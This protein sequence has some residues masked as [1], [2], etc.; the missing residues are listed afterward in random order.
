MAGIVLARLSLLRR[1]AELIREAN[2]HNMHPIA[3]YL[4]LSNQYDRQ[5][6]RHTY[7][8]LG[9]PIQLKPCPSRVTELKKRYP[10]A[11]GG[12]TFYTIQTSG[13]PEH[14]TRVSLQQVL[15]DTT[16]PIL[17][18]EED[19]CPGQDGIGFQPLKDAI[20]LH[21]IGHMRLDV[22]TNK[23][24][25]G[26]LLILAL[27]L[28]IFILCTSSLSGLLWVLGG[29]VALCYCLNHI[30]MCYHEKYAERY[31]MQ[32]SSELGMIYYIAYT[33][34]ES[35]RNK[36]HPP[37]LWQRLS[38]PHPNPQAVADMGK[39]MFATRFSRNYDDIEL[40]CIQTLE[41]A[42]AVMGNSNSM[43]CHS[44][45]LTAKWSQLAPGT[46]WGTFYNQCSG[47]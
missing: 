5:S 43:R 8:Y 29:E 16:D 41:A 14:W 28:V 4:G 32:H 44:R 18:G 9:N 13:Y 27:A 11:T 31:A 38:D 39:K 35:Q 1:N 25:R 34:W 42:F 40:T 33:I 21:E 24:F 37:S 30:Y 10:R 23:P 2:K 12:L 19:A 17:H 3:R 46:N 7:Y 26:A 47:R 20:A 22:S 36:Q 15:G 6:K 45:L